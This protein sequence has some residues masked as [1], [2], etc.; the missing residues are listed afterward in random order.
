MKDPK[1]RPDEP[2]RIQRT[3]EYDT[4]KIDPKDLFL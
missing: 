2:Y 4:V 3:L 1:V